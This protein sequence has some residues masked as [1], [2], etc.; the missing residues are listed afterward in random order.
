MDNSVVIVICMFN[1]SNKM[2]HTVLSLRS[3]SDL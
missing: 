2:K 3:Y 1:D